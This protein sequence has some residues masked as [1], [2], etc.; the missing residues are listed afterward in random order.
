MPE[1]GHHVRWRAEQR[2]GL[3]PQV[4]PWAFVTPFPLPRSLPQ[5]TEP[6]PPH[7]AAL[8]GTGPSSS[9][10]PGKSEVWGLGLV[11]LPPSPSVLFRG[12]AAPPLPNSFGALGAGPKVPPLSSRVWGPGTAAP[13]PPQAPAAPGG[14]DGPG[15]RRVTKAGTTDLQQGVGSGRWA[16]A[17]APGRRGPAAAGPGHWALRSADLLPERPHPASPWPGS[18][19][20]NGAPGNSPDLPRLK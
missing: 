9:R 12:W 5:V 15:G 8:P 6:Q 14:C 18:G 7:P 4:R 1:A 10:L 3:W 16:A 19:L 2:P 11:A 17:Q 13:S 20:R